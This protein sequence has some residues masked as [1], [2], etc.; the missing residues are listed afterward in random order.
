MRS[1]PKSEPIT[2]T[3]TCHTP[4][5]I[6]CATYRMPASQ[7]F[8]RFH[9]SICPASIHSSS[10]LGWCRAVG[11]MDADGGWTRRWKGMLRDPNYSILEYPTRESEDVLDGKTVQ[12]LI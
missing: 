5:A 3:I 1:I 4:C 10:D 2:I 6:Q 8:G 11:T 12:G 9:V 7:F